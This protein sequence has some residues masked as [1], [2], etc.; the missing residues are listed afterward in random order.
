VQI[1]FSKA[2]SYEAGGNALWMEN[3]RLASVKGTGTEFPYQSPLFVVNVFKG[4]TENP[5]L[6]LAKVPCH[7][8]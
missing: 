4:D 8:L 2:W 1:V 6:Y 3:I 7:W 5:N